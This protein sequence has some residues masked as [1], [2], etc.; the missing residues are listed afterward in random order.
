MEHYSFVKFWYKMRETGKET[1]SLLKVTLG[2][3]TSSRPLQTY[4]KH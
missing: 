2:N 4:E 1:N 3:E